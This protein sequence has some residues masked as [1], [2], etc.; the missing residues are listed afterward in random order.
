[1]FPQAAQEDPTVE[2]GLKLCYRGEGRL[3]D[4]LHPPGEIEGAVPDLI[5]PS[6]TC[7]IATDL[8][9]LV[10][11]G[12]LRVA[13]RQHLIRCLEVRLYYRRTVLGSQR[14]SDCGQ[15]PASLYRPV[16]SVHR[17]HAC[18]HR[19]DKARRD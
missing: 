14:P 16:H 2:V 4:N 15:S 3:Q 1:M 8:P 6:Y 12:T 13:M 19:L 7:A 17:M 10:I 18:M 5:T 9:K 11:R